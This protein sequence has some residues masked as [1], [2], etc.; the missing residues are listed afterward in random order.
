M[1]FAL[2]LAVLIL[3]AAAA[4]FC[5]WDR[6]MAKLSPEFQRFLRRYDP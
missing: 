4:F 1:H 3:V 5:G 2:N 6:A